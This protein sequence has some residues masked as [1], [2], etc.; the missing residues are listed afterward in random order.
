MDEPEE[1]TTHVIDTSVLEH[2]QRL[3]D[4]IED[5]GGE[6]QQ[7][8]DA[9]EKLRQSLEYIPMSQGPVMEQMRGIGEALERIET[10]VAQMSE[11]SLGIVSSSVAAAQQS[12]REE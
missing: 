11:E 8:R 5:H 12:P 9:I 3:L 10:K 2:V 6:Y 4:H 1:S 7:G